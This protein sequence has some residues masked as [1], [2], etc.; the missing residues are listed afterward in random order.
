MKSKGSGTTRQPPQPLRGFANVGVGSEDPIDLCDSDVDGASGVLMHDPIRTQSRMSTSRTLLSSSASSASKR[1]RQP[2]SD[3][4][5]WSNM[6]NFRR[7]SVTTS[8]SGGRG[9]GGGE[10]MR[11]GRRDKRSKAAPSRNGRGKGKGQGKR[12]KETYNGK[13]DT[14]EDVGGAEVRF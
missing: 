3:A 9:D 4:R 10:W 2:G 6:T 7:P 13:Y 12:K 11:Q 1:R 5:S 14:L 8:R